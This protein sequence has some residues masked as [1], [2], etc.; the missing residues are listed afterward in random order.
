MGSI[1]A[2]GGGEIADAETRPIDERAVEAAPG[3]SPTALFI[4]TASGDAEGY[5]E[6]FEGYYG[7]ILGCETACLRLTEPETGR[8]EAE[9]AI[10]A[11]DLIYVGG[12]DTG[13]LVD[14]IQSLDLSDH[15]YRH[16][17]DGGVLMGLSAGALCWFPWSLSDAIAIEEIAYGPTSGLG[18][19]EGL[20]ATVHADF[21]RRRAFR[22]YLE[23]REAPGLAIGDCAAV[24]IRDDAY[25]VH[26]ASP[27]AIV[28]HVDP[29]LEEP[30]Q[31]LEPDPSFTPLD[32]LR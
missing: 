16:W 26:T 4:P 9:A 7:E 20:H 18:F 3:S 22:R 11:A 28:A 27:E 6:N 21:E 30:V 31:F 32:S 5:I 12:G 24:E 13:Y 15:L 14:M 23:P 8:P 29:R 17:Q 19:V 1:I 10:E 25:R 2:I